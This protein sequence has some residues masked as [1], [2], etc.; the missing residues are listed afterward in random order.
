[1]TSPDMAA[2]T[3]EALIALLKRR[4][5]LFELLTGVVAPTDASNQ[6]G[7]SLVI[8]N[9]AHI[10]VIL[11]GDTNSINAQSLVGTVVI[12]SCVPVLY[13]PPTGY[14]IIGYLDV[15]P[16]TPVYYEQIITSGSTTT[17]LTEQVVYTTTGGPS[18]NG[19]V[20]FKDGHAYYIDV[21]SQVHTP[22]AQN[23]TSLIRLGSLT[24]TSLLGGPRLQLPATNQDVD[25]VRRGY[26]INNT[27]ADINDVLVVT[28]TPQSA[29]AVTFNSGVTAGRYI[30][31]TDKGAISQYPGA[32]VV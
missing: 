23:P 29:N 9:P 16:N 4:R 19:K 22:I 25:Y 6:L 11:D 2:T 32:N 21:F 5:M 3:V 13:V 8:S 24:G 17:S 18:G 15:P 12:G 27:G 31:V 10:T 7:T 28:I 30:E 1:M 14:Y 26:V 20:L